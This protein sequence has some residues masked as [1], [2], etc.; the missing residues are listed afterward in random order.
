MGVLKARFILILAMVF[1]FNAPGFPASGPGHRA[2]PV[3]ARGPCG[4]H[5]GSCAV[6]SVCAPSCGIGALHSGPAFWVALEVSPYRPDAGPQGSRLVY[7][8]P[9]PP[10]RIEA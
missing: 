7:P 4:S 9:I 3:P 8:P 2:C 5:Q 1:A 6:C 10:P